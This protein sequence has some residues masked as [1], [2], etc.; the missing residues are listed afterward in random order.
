LIRRTAVASN[1][2]PTPPKRGLGCVADWQFPSSEREKNIAATAQ[3]WLYRAAELSLRRA[4]PGV[5]G[6]VGKSGT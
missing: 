1:P 3:L 5:R 4:N 2:T 6:K